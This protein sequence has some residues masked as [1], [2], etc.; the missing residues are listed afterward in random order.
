MRPRTARSEMMCTWATARPGRW[1]VGQLRQPGGL[2]GR[3]WCSRSGRWR[4]R[5]PGVPSARSW[6]EN[7][8]WALFLWTPRGRNHATRAFESRQDGPDV[9]HAEVAG[10]GDEVFHARAA[11]DGAGRADRGAGVGGGGGGAV[12]VGVPGG[13]RCGGAGG[14]LRSRAGGGGAGG[15]DRARAGDRR[16]RGHGWDLGIDDYT[17]IWFFQQAG[18]RC[19]S[20]TTT[21]PA[22][23]GWQRWCAR[24]SRA[25]LAVG[26]HHLP[27]DVM[28]RELATGRRATRRWVAGAVADRVGAAADRR[29]G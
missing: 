13:L 10:D 22:A 18:A 2:A 23:W 21:R 14:V 27:H 17:A 8:G 4:G 7:D 20:S 9:V 28:V 29:S 26:T 24:R 19:G 15:A 12:R 1:W 3:G 16:C 6:L 5:R 11:G 25:G